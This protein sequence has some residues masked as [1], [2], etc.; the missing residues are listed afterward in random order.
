MS[1]YEAHRKLGQGSHPAVKNMVRTGMVTGIELDPTSK[2]E[3][4][5]ACAKAKSRTQPYPQESST[6][7]QITASVFTG[8]HGARQQ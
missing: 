7:L 5:G 1:L 4:C 3:F 6:E 2:E 8:T